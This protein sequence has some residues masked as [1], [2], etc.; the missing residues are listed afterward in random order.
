[1]DQQ[2]NAEGDTAADLGR[3]HQSEVL[4][5]ARRRLLQARSYWYPIMLDLHR[6]MIAVARVTVNHDGRGGTAPDPSEIRVASL[7]LGL[8]LFL[9]LFLVLL[10]SWVGP[11]FRFMVVTFMVLILLPGH[12]VLAFSFLIT[13]FLGTLH[14]PMGSEDVGH[15]WGFF[16]GTSYPFRA[17]GWSPVA[18]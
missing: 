12:T 8:M 2:G 5:D 18:Q 11:G 1:M 14:W 13:A 3:C 7:I 4:I 9:L 17:M 6:F 10:A 16:S 15:F